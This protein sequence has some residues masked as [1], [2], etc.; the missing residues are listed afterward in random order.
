MR[1]IS[2]RRK[3]KFLQQI[4]S[5]KIN[6]YKKKNKKTTTGIFLTSS[7]S[8]AF[9]FWHLRILHTAHSCISV[10]KLH[11]YIFFI[12]SIYAFKLN[13]VHR[14]RMMANDNIVILRIKGFR[15]Y[16]Q[17]HRTSDKLEDEFS[18]LRKMQARLFG[19]ILV[20]EVFIKGFVSLIRR[21]SLRN[22]CPLGSC[23]SKVIFIYRKC[24]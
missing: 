2:D 24:L 21:S 13:E 7:N 20:K 23:L 22:I 17:F 14:M 10:E 3:I 12:K 19:R 18:N 11:I 15:L 4:W 5:C 8:H 6:Y 16:L 9:L 1:H